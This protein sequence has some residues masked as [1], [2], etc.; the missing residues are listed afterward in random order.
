[1]ICFDLR[2]P[3]LARLMAL[4]GAAAVV[5]PAAFNM[6][7]GPVHWELLMQARAIDN[8]TYVLACAPARDESAGYVSFANSLAV[9]P[10]GKTL[11]RLGEKPDILYCELD[12]SQTGSLREQVP[13]L[14]ARRDD[15][16]TLEWKA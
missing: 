15:L 2:F 4:N 16:Y 8:F 1:M 10:W 11:A 14:S 12:I 7:T 9:S 6:T 5:V 13:V 3:E